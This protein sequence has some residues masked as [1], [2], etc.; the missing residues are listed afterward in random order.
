MDSITPQRNKGDKGQLDNM[1]LSHEEIK[2]LR[3]ISETKQVNERSI[4][5]CVKQT[6]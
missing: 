1:E 3:I 6:N 4:K 5:Y 2:N